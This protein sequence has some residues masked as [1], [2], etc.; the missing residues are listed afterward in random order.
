MTCEM[1]YKR[2]GWGG[3]NAARVEGDIKG[4]DGMKVGEFS[5]TWNNCLV[6]KVPAKEEVEVWR[7]NDKIENWDHLYH[8]TLF[9]LQLNYMHEGL[10]QR[11]PPTDCRYR[12]D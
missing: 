12:P 9:G 4:A 6:V 7:I 8:F 1:E 10:V 11:I 2:K 5:G 3:K